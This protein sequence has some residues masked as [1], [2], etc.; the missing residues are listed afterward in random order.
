MPELKRNNIKKLVFK[1]ICTLY[2]SGDLNVVLLILAG[3][4]CYSFLP[5]DTCQVSP[6]PGAMPMFRNRVYSLRKY[7]I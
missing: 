1:R 5:A 7:A 4:G 6:G 3:V 2:S